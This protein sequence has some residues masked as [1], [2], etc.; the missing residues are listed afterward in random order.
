MTEAA[1]SVACVARTPPPPQ[2]RLSP[3]ASSPRQ[4]TAHAFEQSA[5]LLAATAILCKL[6]GTVHV[7]Y[8]GFDPNQSKYFRMAINPEHVLLCFILRGR[9]VMSSLFFLAASCSVTNLVRMSATLTALAGSALTASN[10]GTTTV[11]NQVSS[12]ECRIGVVRIKCP[13]T[14]GLTRIRSY[15][16]PETDTSA[17]SCDHKRLAVRSEPHEQKQRQGQPCRRSMRSE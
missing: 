11:R 1:G 17:Y 13:T 9:T 16:A 5:I 3:S 4:C 2:S 12:I 8:P 6:T 7:V 15:S 10:E 14:T